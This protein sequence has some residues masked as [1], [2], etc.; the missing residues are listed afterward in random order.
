MT[1]TQEDDL[2]VR[3]MLDGFGAELRQWVARKRAFYQGDYIVG[4]DHAAKQRCEW[5]QARIREYQILG[6]IPSLV[7]LAH[8][9]ATQETSPSFRGAD[10]EQTITFQV[11]REVTP[12][13]ND[14]R[15]FVDAMAYKLKKNAHKGRWES[16]SLDAALTMLEQEVQEMREATRAGNTV[17]IV[18]EAADVANFAMIAASIAIDKGGEHGPTGG[19]RREA[20][21]RATLDNS[22]NHP[23]AERDGTLSAGGDN[24]EEAGAV[25]ER[26]VPKKNRGNS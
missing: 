12:Y 22:E 14:L 24:R 5:L 4:I 8:S 11:P 2:L 25:V 18:L 9:V 6:S 1:A 13:M 17:E 10:V 16:L 26:R 15:R 7:K 21:D 23:E 3:Q 20:V 19:I